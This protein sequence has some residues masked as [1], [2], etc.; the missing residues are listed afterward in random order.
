[1]PPKPPKQ[2]QKLVKLDSMLDLI[3]QASNIAGNMADMAS[4]PDQIL[5]AMLAIKED[6]ILRFDGHLNAIEGLQA[7]LKMITVH[8]TEGEDRI[9]TNQDDIV[10]LLAKNT[11]MK[12]TIQELVHKVDYLENHSHRSNLCLVGIP[13]SREGTCVCE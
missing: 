6:F 8:V 1:M 3:K 12:A 4:D 9:S 11:A 10:K 7:Q 13:Q 5:F 2:M